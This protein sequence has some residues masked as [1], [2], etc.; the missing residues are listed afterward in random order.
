MKKKKYLYVLQHLK[1]VCNCVQYRA[2]TEYM[3]NALHDRMHANYIHSIQAH[4]YF[5]C[6]EI[7]WYGRFR[8]RQ[9]RDNSSPTHDL[10][11]DVTTYLSSAYQRLTNT[12]LEQPIRNKIVIHKRPFSIIC[13]I[14]IASHCWLRWITEH[15]SVPLCYRDDGTTTFKC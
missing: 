8:R 3:L 10:K 4:N 11:N 5:V 14:T 2:K 9:Y 7:K 1:T 15:V 6:R 13:D 12:S